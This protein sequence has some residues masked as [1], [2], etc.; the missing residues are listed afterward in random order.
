MAQQITVQDIHA[1]LSNGESIT[2]ID[3]REDDEIAVSKLDSVTHIPMQDIPKNMENLPK[4]TPLYIMCRIGGRS[5]QVA[6]FLSNLGYNAINI[7]GGMKAWQQHIDPT[8]D[9]A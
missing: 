5:E 6:D 2:I 7:T 1:K 9:V 4:D 8:L 3:V